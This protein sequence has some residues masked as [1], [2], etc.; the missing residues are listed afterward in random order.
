MTG[1]ETKDGK[2]ANFSARVLMARTEYNFKSKSGSFTIN[3]NQY[4]ARLCLKMA[5]HGID[6]GSSEL[7]LEGGEEE[8]QFRLA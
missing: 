6:T 5:G 3:G 8:M 7:T 2:G 4:K 1:S